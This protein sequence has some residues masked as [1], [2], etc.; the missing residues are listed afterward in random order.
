MSKT[1]FKT[2][3]EKRPAVAIL[4]FFFQG[5][6]CLFLCALGFFLHCES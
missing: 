6:F 2:T 5:V 4:S 1:T 3:Q